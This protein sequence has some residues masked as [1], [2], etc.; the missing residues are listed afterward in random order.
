M[1]ERKRKREKGREKKEERKRKREER[2]RCAQSLARPLKRQR[3]Q[4]PRFIEGPAIFRAQRVLL[5]SR[6]FFLYIGGH[7]R[8]KIKGICNQMHF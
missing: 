4:V 2:T 3:F 6:R 1:E 7:T 8:S 5:Y